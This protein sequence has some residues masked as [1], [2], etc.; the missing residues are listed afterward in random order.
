MKLLKPDE[1]EVKWLTCNKTLLSDGIVSSNVPIETSDF[2]LT[3]R[4][5]K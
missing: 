4:N 3:Q 1:I 5:N 2:N